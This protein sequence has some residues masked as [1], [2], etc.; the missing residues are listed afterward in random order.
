MTLLTFGSMPVVQMDSSAGSGRLILFSGTSQTIIAGITLTRRHT[1]SLVLAF[2]AG[3]GVNVWLDGTQVAANAPNGAGA[4]GVATLLHDTTSGGGAQCWFHEAAWWT[5][6]LTGADI[7]TLLSYL[8]RWTRG[9]RR[10][11][12]IL[13]NGQSNAVNGYEDGAWHLMAQGVAWY[14]GALAAYVAGRR[15]QP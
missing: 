2:A 12:N 7:T 6:A 15:A 4:G 11:V 3:G 1:H 8:T 9:T 13:V 5:S 14:I 10:G